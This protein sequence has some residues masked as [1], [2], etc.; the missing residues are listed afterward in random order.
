MRF[1]FL[2]AILLI[3][4]G[5]GIA[6]STSAT[7]PPKPPPTSTPRPTSTPVGDTRASRALPRFGSSFPLN[8][9][10]ESDRLSRRVTTLTQY[11]APLYRKATSK[12]LEAIA[13]SPAIRQQYAA[14]LS[15]PNSG[16]FRLV[17][18]TGCATNYKVV[19]AKEECLK[20]SMPGSGS[21]YSFRTD[22]Y[23]VRQLADITFREN[24]FYITG[25]FMHGFIAKVENTAFE[26]VSLTTP[27]L[28]FV[29]E[30]K[31]SINADDVLEVDANLS[32]GVERGGSLFS[33]NIRAEK[34]GVYVL[35]A[36]AYRGKVVRSAVGIRY[37]ELDY[38]KREDLVVAFK[39]VDLGDDGSVTI[40]WKTLAEKE[41]PRIK[42][43]EVTVEKKRERSVGE[44]E[45]N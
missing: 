10:S 24:S 21:S 9:L 14:L 36:V 23:R 11:V 25:L 6:Q 37:N 12:E 7:P 29:S 33:K 30:F 32:K 27:G 15:L 2:C 18:D 40:I 19:S 20:Y 44:G 31:P 22:G 42:M 34:D 1:V 43:P 3:G 5:S 28:G 4:V 38:D 35:R 26:S 39:V 13:P 17:N 16:I 41:V 45:G 8:P